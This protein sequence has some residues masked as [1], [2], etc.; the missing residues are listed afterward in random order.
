MGPRPV[1][2]LGRAWIYDLYRL[3]KNIMHV[4]ALASSREG[5]RRVK[6]WEDEG[7]APPAATILT[8]P[9]FAEGAIS[10]PVA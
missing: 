6:V 5:G 7:Q 8:P 2:S 3:T 9:D 1:H 4:L 10:T